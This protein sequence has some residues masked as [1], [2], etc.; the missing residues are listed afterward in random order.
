ML[1]GMKAFVL[2]NHYILTKVMLNEARAS[3]SRN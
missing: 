1:L 3:K 2:L